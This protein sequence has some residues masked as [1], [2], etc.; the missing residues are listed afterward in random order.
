MPAPL[1]ASVRATNHARGVLQAKG[2]TTGKPAVVTPVAPPVYRPQPTP[3]ALRPKGAAVQRKV[4]PESSGRTAA[5]PALRAGRGEF[6]Q[7]K[8]ASPP[9]AGA[10]SKAR[11]HEAPAGARTLSP[12]RAARTNVAQP[13]THVTSRARP[14]PA[15]RGAGGVVQRA[16]EMTTF[17]PAPA[18]YPAGVYT[19]LHVATHRRFMFGVTRTAR[20]SGFDIS[21]SVRESDGTTH[22]GVVTGDVVTA[23]RVAYLRHIDVRPITSHVPGLGGLLI[24]IFAAHVNAIADNIE[25]TTMSPAAAGFYQAVGFPVQQTATTYFNQMRTNAAG[26][27][28]LI[29]AWTEREQTFTNAM[30]NPGQAQGAL[31]GIPNP[32][33]ATAAIRA[34]NRGRLTAWR[35]PG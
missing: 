35:R 4:A 15:R 34:A 14:A 23:A 3:A 33:A 6:V 25:V 12:V 1:A 21:I 18:D 10:P 30:N 28:E 29:A 27:A 16:V 22:G 20:A 9:R 7:A 26:N 32:T 11:P 5:P 19:L 31:P 13:Y 24:Y 17:Y 2:S 8:A